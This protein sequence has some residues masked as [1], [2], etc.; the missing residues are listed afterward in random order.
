MHSLFDF[1][2]EDDLIDIRARL[3]NVFGPGPQTRPTLYDPMDALLRSVLSARTKDEVSRKVHAD[4]RAHW[5][6]WS[7]LA[8]ATEQEIA[9][10]IAPVTFASDKARHLVLTLKHIAV[11]FPD[12]DLT[13][14]QS[15]PV[16]AVR[17]WLQSLPGIGP[18]TASAVMNFSGLDQAAMVLDT[19]VL[20]CLRRLG[21]IGAKAT[22]DNAYDLIM[23]AADNWDGADLSELHWLLKRL[24]HAFCHAT[25]PACAD[26]PLKGRCPATV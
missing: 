11:R 5:P 3:E 20:R 21:V 9:E 13:S 6:T 1:G 17:G 8:T 12:F 7:Q 22:A 26:C 16:E 25:Q 10:L 14:L 24:G 19:H 23:T 4:V 2:L 15:L 18:R